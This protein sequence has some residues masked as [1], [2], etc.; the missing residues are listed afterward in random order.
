MHRSTRNILRRI[1]PALD[2]L[3]APLSWAGGWWLS[4]ARQIG[5]TRL[6][7]TRAILARCGVH[8]LRNHFYEPYPVEAMADGPRDLPGVDLGEP[9]Q[10]ALLDE[11]APF[12]GELLAMAD[13]APAKRAFTFA[14]DSFGP[15]DAEILYALLRARTPHTVLELGSGMSTLMALEAR[16]ATEALSPGRGH[17]H[18]VVDPFPKPWLASL[19]VEVRA[20]KAEDEDP[21]SLAA[22]LGPGDILFI[23][24]SHVVRPGGDV[25]VA[26]LD[27]IPRLPAG[28]LVHAHDIFTPRD[29]PAKWAVHQRRLWTEQYL[30][31]ALL[32]GGTRLRTLAA[33]N[34]LRHAHPAALARV[35]PVLGR[36]LKEGNAVEPGSFWMITA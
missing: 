34:H 22:L 4:M 5:L 24:S 8:P 7:V 6:P 21:A 30:L 2:I 31:E 28:V 20:R 12:A 13:R 14:N 26:Y 35:C 25:L 33:V 23:D 32:S 11:L 19:G 1:A 15:G 9:D 16:A 18:I 36:F 29:Y 3:L 10:L 17:T 27:I